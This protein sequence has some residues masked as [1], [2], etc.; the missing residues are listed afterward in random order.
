MNQVKFAGI[1]L[2]F[3]LIW[4]G[5]CNDEPPPKEPVEKG[6]L[7]TDKFAGWTYYNHENIRIFYPPDHPHIDRFES[8]AAGYLTALAGITTALK[9]ELPTDTIT[10]LFYPD[11]QTGMRITG[12]DYQFVEGNL[13]H[14]WLPGYYGVTLT[15]WLLPRWQPGPVRQKFLR[16]GLIT[17]FDHSGQDYHA[18]TLR[19]IDEDRFLP[20]SKLA[21]DDAINSNRERYNSTEAASFCAFILAWYGPEVLQGMYRYQNDFETLVRGAF[22]LS[23]DSLELLWIEAIRNNK[24]DTISGN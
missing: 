7:S 12:Q 6:P 18:A 24:L 9:T 5:S 14:F 22:D 20:L 3:S 1:I 2:L 4:I 10:V 15:Q 23:V 21:V 13:I 11:Y 8:I 19:F 17:L 16:H